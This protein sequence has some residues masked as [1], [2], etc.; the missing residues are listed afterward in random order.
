[1]SI[2]DDFKADEFI[3]NSMFP[4]EPERVAELTSVDLEASLLL[5]FSSAEAGFVSPDFARHHALRKIAREAHNEGCELVALVNQEY[6]GQ[7]EVTDGDIT[8]TGYVWLIEAIGIH[9]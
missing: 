2:D 4:Y 5:Y 7:E 6:L 9:L 1:M 8:Y 3:K